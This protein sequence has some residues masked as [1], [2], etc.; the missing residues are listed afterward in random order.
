MR[1]WLTEVPD[2]AI[3]F[4]RYEVAQQIIA[5]VTVALVT[6]VS[7]NG[8]IRGFQLFS[9]LTYILRLPSIYILL[10]FFRNPEYAY[11]VTTVAVIVL[12]IGRVYYAHVKCQLPVVYFL[13]RVVMPCVVVSM[14]VCLAL[15]LIVISLEPSFVRLMVSV[16]VSTLTLIVS[17]FCF[18]LDKEEKEMVKSVLL[19]LKQKISRI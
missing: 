6:M 3:L 19:Q 10:K 1:L 12:C 4:C 7:G 15:S 18:A 5:S 13:S 16:T 9:S 8:D 11:W 17:I 2:Y 14:F